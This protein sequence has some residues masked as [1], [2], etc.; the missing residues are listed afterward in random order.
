M[1]IILLSQWCAP[2]PDVRIYPL[3]VA[4]SNR[5]HQVTTVTGFPNYPQGKIYPGYRQKLWQWEE[6]D[7]VRILRLPLYPDRSR[8]AIRRSLNYLSFAAT[9]SSIGAALCGAADIIWVYHPPLTIGIPAQWISLIRRIPFVYEIQDLWPETVEASGMMSQ[10]IPLWLLTQLSQLIYRRSA[11]ITV[12]SPGFKRNLCAKGIPADKIHVIPNWA[13]EEIYRPVDRDAILGLDYE[14]AD[15]FNVMFAG[16]MGP[17]Q[18]LQV[19]IQ[20]ASLLQDITDLQFIFIGDGIDIPTLKA[21]VEE[22]KLTNVRFIE[23]KPS[24][25]MPHF[26]AWADGLLVQLRDEPLFHLT[27]P[28]KTLSYL[29]CGR[30]IVCAVPGAGADV[31]KAAGAGLICPPSSPHELARAVRVLYDMPKSEREALGQAGRQAFLAYYTREKLVD[32]YETLFRNVIQAQISK[33]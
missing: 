16:N 19:A 33:V 12:I 24:A 2:E 6:K 7:G 25:E 13:D 10:R 8:S 29:A 4:L 9:A 3:A 5:G 26:F 17:A 23:R 31:V 1:R 14:L 21:S 27:I 28:S 20:A 22:K 32:H 30:P 18:N 11:A 15:H